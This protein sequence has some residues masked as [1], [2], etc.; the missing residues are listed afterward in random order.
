MSPHRSSALLASAALV[1]AIAAAPCAAFA[2]DTTT[3]PATT[4][5]TTTITT[6]DLV[7]ALEAAVQPTTEAEKAG[8]SVQ[9]TVHQ[10]GQALVKVSAIYA[11]TRGSLSAGSQGPVIQAEHS[12]TYITVA[13]LA[14]EVPGLNLR[15][16]LKA[17]GRASAQ[18]VFMPEKK[19]DLL[20]GVDGLLTDVVP[21]AAL[22]TL[23]DPKQTTITGAPTQ[24]VADD[25]S[26]TYQF[27]ATDSDEETVAG[28][29]TIGADGAIAEL[30][31]ATATEEDASTFAYGTQH[32]ALPAAR[33]TVTIDQLVTGSILADL[34]SAVHEIAVE[35]A[36]RAKKKAHKHA[37]KAAAIRSAAGAIAKSFDRVLGV[38]AV[39]TRAIAGGVR[40]T[41]TDR[42]IHSRVS[43]TV[44]AA[45]KKAVVRRG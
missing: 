33:A 18:W 21:D 2:D 30:D 11:L 40:I 9:G 20:T 41:G 12:G 8:W 10:N 22:A 37:V 25:G 7:A 23:V 24:T 45:G 26:T 17:I 31:A 28:T 43:Y 34:P 5:G 16:S 13:A 44:K 35:T 3:P 39:T 29:V 36:D 6:D 14:A 32:V 38:K 15:R 4:T 42:H 19:V 27:T 1:T